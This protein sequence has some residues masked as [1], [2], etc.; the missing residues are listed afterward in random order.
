MENI[1]LDMVNQIGLYC[2]AEQLKLSVAESVTSGYLQ[3][4]LSQG[5]GA[6]DY[7]QGGITLY[8]NSQKE[9]LFGISSSLTSSN[10]GVSPQVSDL[11]AKGS[12]SHFNSDIAIGITG[13]AH[14]DKEFDVEE[15]FCY[16]SIA[17]GDKIIYRVQVETNM[18]SMPKN[19]KYFGHQCIAGLLK[20]LQTL[21]QTA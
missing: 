6:S 14:K 1:L 2:Q 3:Y 11:L 16:I 21:K 7:Y 18:N 13:F 19:Q 9:H 12:N 5:D 20:T 4:L 10:N 17:L 15:P 8:N